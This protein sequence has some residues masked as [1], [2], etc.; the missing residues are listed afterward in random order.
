MVMLFA[1]TGAN[2][3][4]FI[5]LP[6]D[7]SITIQPTRQGFRAFKNR[8]GQIVSYE[9]KAKFMPYFRKFIELRSFLLQGKD[10]P[11]LFFTINNGTP[12]KITQDFIYI[13]FKQARDIIDPDLEP[14][15]ASEFRKY[16][17]EWSANNLT[18]ED[19]ARLAQNTEQVFSEK[20]SRGNTLIQAIEISNYFTALANRVNNTTLP[21]SKIAAGE[22]A[23]FNNP[24]Q[25]INLIPVSCS[26]HICCIFCEHFL[27]HRNKEDIWKLLSI[28]HICSDLTK[29]AQLGDEETIKLVI[30]AINSLIA[31]LSKDCSTKEIIDECYS[32]IDEGYLADYWQ[33][34]LDLLVN[35]GLV[36]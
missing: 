29:S 27:M 28:K 32:L 25:I 13:Y 2:L 6:W 15:N 4:V 16:K 23:E 3:S 31:E 19:G 9:I 24:I 21:T 33:H 14:I 12:R 7:S 34:Y 22:C 36:Q 26:T 5:D 10:Y 20:Y 35:L 18:I 1:V 8:A 11:F 17:T 30:V